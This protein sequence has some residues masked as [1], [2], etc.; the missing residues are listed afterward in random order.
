MKLLAPENLQ[1][2][3]RFAHSVGQEF[4]NSRIKLIDLQ[5][6]KSGKKMT[7][8]PWRGLLRIDFLVCRSGE[9]IIICG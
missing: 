9:K 1:E 5:E 8:S 2:Y 7:I 6:Q 4:A 3:F